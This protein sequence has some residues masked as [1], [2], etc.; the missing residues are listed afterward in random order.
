VTLPVLVFRIDV[1]PKTVDIAV[2]P[3]VLPDIVTPDLDV[4]RLPTS[5]DGPAKV[6]SVSA[7]VRRTGLETKLLVQGAFGPAH[8]QADR[9]LLRLIAQARRFN[10]LLLSSNGA[11]IA[12][13]AARVGVSRSYFTRVFRLSFLAPE[14]AKAILQGHQ[15]SELSAIKLMGAGRFASVWSD[16]R[17]Q[18]GFD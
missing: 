15:P 9:S 18:L 14:I 16:Q 3:A 2:R 13:L 1:R 12:E 4:R 6:L 7:K 11:T 10:D 17:R 5:P 8:R